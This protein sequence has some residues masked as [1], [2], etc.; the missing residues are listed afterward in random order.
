M[1]AWKVEFG[2]VMDPIGLPRVMVARAPTAERAAK[3]VLDWARRQ[4]LHICVDAVT[5]YEGKMFGDG[6][7]SY[8]EVIEAQHYF[9]ALG[10][11]FKLT[12]EFKE[13]WII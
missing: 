12:K 3:R 10:R 9:A 11:K 6:N 7:A 4:G 5:Q 13:N 1:K 2:D 8:A